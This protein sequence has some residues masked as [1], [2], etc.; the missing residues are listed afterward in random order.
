MITR[1]PIITVT[2]AALA[3]A[4]AAG[5]AVAMPDDVTAN[6]SHVP[7]GSPSVSHQVTQSAPTAPTIVRVSAPTG[8][9]DWGDAG[10]G[11]AGG[12]AI[13]MIAIGGAFVTSQRRSRRSD[14]TPALS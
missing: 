8:S 12:F 1:R 10:I 3:L 13:S 4:T 5:P 11:A 2:L 7:A 14:S 9:F 6:G